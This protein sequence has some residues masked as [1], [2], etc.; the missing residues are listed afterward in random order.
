MRL[1]S[2]TNLN[3]GEFFNAQVPR[4]CVLS[5]RW[6]DDEVTYQDVLNNTINTL[7]NGYKKIFGACQLAR[8]RDYDWIWVDTC[9]I[10]KESSAELQ[11][12]INSMFE[13]Y[14]QADLCIAYLVDVPTVR[15][16]RI[17][18]RA[19]TEFERRQRRM[20]DFRKSVWFTRGWTLQELL[21]PAHLEFFDHD[22][23][24]IGSKADLSD[25]ISDTTEIAPQY[26]DGQRRVNEASVA[27]RMSWASRGSTTRIEDQA[28]CLLGIFGISMT[29]LYGEGSM[30]FYRLQ[31]EILANSDD[32]SIFA[33]IVRDA[34]DDELFGMLAESPR[35]FRHSQCVHR[36]RSHLFE[37]PPVSIPG[38]GLHFSHGFRWKEKKTVHEKGRS[39]GHFMHKTFNRR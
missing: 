16:T 17:D 35:H 33:W 3:F 8:S 38:G 2:T 37:K 4:Y 36:V 20:E 5:H 9:C 23:K 39:C 29:S 30:A 26:L 32:E 7:A 14:A 19:N 34:T 27:T 25:E 15:E 12:T 11:E 1:L 6:G 22:F 13:F 10:N 21:A 31:R 18:L 24:L 28:Y